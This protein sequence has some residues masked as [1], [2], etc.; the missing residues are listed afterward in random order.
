[1]ASHRSTVYLRMLLEMTGSETELQGA[2]VRLAP[3]QL[4]MAGV[5]LSFSV[6]SV[7]N[8]VASTGVLTMH[9]PFRFLSQRRCWTR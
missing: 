2:R 3:Y 7:R 6:V 9:S 1:V 5:C 8:V 4:V